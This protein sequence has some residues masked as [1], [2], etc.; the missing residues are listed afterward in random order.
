[1]EKEEQILIGVSIC[2]LP[3]CPVASAA[4]SVANGLT[5]YTRS[6]QNLSCHF[7]VYLFCLSKFFSEPK[8]RR[9][10]LFEKKQILLKFF[11]FCFMDSP[12]DMQKNKKEVSTTQTQHLL[13]VILGAIHQ[14]LFP[15]T[16]V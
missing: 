7:Y 16:N 13:I 4:S 9:L 6:Q 8:K 10:R 1:M 5:D 2:C 15:R 14:P 12:P 11:C 3:N